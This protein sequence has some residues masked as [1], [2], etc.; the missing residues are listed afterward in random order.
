MNGQIEVKLNGRKVTV[1]GGPYRDKPS[2]VRGV[3]L[4]QEIN[5]F[6]DVVLD[7]PDFGVPTLEALNQP[8]YKAL[9][10]LEEDG[11]IYVGC[12]G[13]IGRTGMF[14]ALLVKTLGALAYHRARDSW[15]GRLKMKFGNYPANMDIAQ[16][17]AYPVKYVRDR[18]L[19][20][21]V[22]T[23]EQEELVKSFKADDL[24][25]VRFIY[26]QCVDQAGK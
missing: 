13:G 3:K 4:A 19:D 23:S 7:V 18:Y 5:A 1:M 6:A 2:N 15:W 10:I 24:I 25:R 14:M 21:A 8:I 11:V 26:K 12:M 9:E 22:E 16:Q 17:C 20:H